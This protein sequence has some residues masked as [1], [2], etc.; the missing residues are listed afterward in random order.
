MKS[1][2]WLRLYRSTISNKKI[3]SLGH[4]GIGFW[5]NLL[6]ISDDDGFLGT[7]DDII[8]K[9]KAG[10]DVT[11]DVTVTWC[12]KMC[13][14]NVLHRDVTGRYSLHEWDL[15]QQNLSS[16]AERMRKL[17]NKRKEKQQLS[18][19]VTNGDANGD[20][21]RDVTVTLQT[22]TQR[23]K[24]EEDSAR[25]VTKPNK[26][27]D[28][29]PLLDRFAEA[30]GV[31]T[32]DLLRKS[33]QWMRFAEAFNSWVE[34]GSN[35]ERHIWPTIATIA[36]QQPG[37]I[38]NGPLYFSKAIADATSRATAIASAEQSDAERLATRL[39]IV[40]PDG[41]RCSIAT[42]ED[43][44]ERWSKE[45]FW[46]LSY[47]MPPGHPDFSW[48]EPY[49]KRF[50]DV[51]WPPNR[52]KWYDYRTPSLLPDPRALKSILEQMGENRE[53]A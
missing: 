23:R 52:I 21:Q 14:A 48:P 41:K 12:D 29:R 16:S 15:Y 19:N 17:R 10:C 44:V 51:T 18:L 39:P 30:L 6:C 13:D 33:G 40:L 4:E 5:T 34:K 22:Q 24:E 43:L 8:W 27:G 7:L 1:K 36:K 31:T 32:A 38:P 28:A 50:Q 26:P 35:P 49:A 9:L 53:N 45:R 47:G 25:V 37:F 46:D 2:P 20:K 11:R 3:Q 42:A